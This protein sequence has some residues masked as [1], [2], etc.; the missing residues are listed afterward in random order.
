MSTCTLMKL[1]LATA[2]LVSAPTIS[3]AIDAVRGPAYGPAPPI[4]GYYWTGFYGGGHLGVGWSDGASGFLGGGQAGFN[5]QINKWVLGVEG[6][7][8]GT[9][10]KDNVN[11]TF[12]FPGAIATAHAETSLDWVSTLAPRFGYAFDR[13]LVYGKVGGA[14]AHASANLSANV[15]SPGVGGGIAGTVTQ[16][17]SG[18]ML[19]I[20]TEYALWNNW[21]AK[22]EY[23]MM[24]FGSD[25]PF[26][27]DKFHVFKGGINYHIGG[28]GVPF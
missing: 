14:W 25:S 27:N 11:A 22:M 21:T 17:V 18:W 26:S 13:W 6:Q 15:I 4:F 20:G 16:N 19:G 1:G 5:Y 12:V 8:S 3:D 2:M 23:N 7:F 9:S 28:P 24:D 10:I